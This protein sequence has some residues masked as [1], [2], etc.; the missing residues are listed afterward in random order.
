M[1]VVLTAVPAVQERP[2]LSQ[3]LLRA[4]VPPSAKAREVLPTTRTRAL[5]AVVMSVSKVTERLPLVSTM[6]LTV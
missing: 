6:S 2:V 4:E 1:S 3:N 5:E